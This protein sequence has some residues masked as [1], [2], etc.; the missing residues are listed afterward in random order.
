MMLALGCFIFSIETA[1]YQTLDMSYEVPWVE[2]GRLGRKTAL[3]LPAAANVEFSLTG[4]IYPD[5]KGGYGQLEYLRHMA[6]GGP[7]ILVTGQGLILGKF[8]ILSV[9]ETQSVFHQNGLPKKQEFTVHLKEYGE[10]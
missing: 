5:F 6:H 7:H 1:A 10:D 3:Q 2:Q 8:V 4:V 9:S